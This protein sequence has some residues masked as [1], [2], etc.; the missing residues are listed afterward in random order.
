MIK[1]SLVR[2]IVET[3]GFGK[4]T[5]RVVPDFF[6]QKG[7]V[8]T[9]LNPVSYLT[10]LKQKPLFEAMD[11]IFTDGSLLVR[12]I[13][14]VYGHGVTRRSFDM[15]SMAPELLE[16]AN[17]HRASVC[18]VA[19]RQDKMERTVEL[20]AQQYPNIEWRGCRNG[21]FATR[22]E[23]EDEARKIAEADPDFL[24]VGMGIKMQER[25]L[26]MCKEAGYKGIGFTCGGFIH[27][28]A[29]Q[30]GKVDYYPAWVDKYNLRFFYRMYKEPHT[31]KRYAIA[32][33]AF[34][35][36]FLKEKLTL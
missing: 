10:A 3:E 15:T 21:Y 1:S 36:Q 27:Q 35:Y 25:F 22:Q 2:K 18:V 26:L 12:A 4:H 33:F 32:A 20:F 24:I 7:R 19:T 6:T 29:E 5:N 8:Y 30:E 16:Y 31:R 9:Y 28:T 17:S 23:M 34:P 11:G 14:M 13:K